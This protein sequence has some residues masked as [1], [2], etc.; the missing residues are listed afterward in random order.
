MK[1]I[2]HCM[3]IVVILSLLFTACYKDII[4]PES[5]PDG[6]PQSVSYKEDLAPLFQAKCT[7]VG[8]HV[9][10][11][12]KPYMD[13]TEESFRNIVNGGFVNTFLPKESILYK[14]VNG[15]MTEFIPSKKDKQLVYDWIRNG[16]PNN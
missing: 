5:D 10:G 14:Q 2:N 7:N 11:G 4:S 8:C 6:P 3:V 12:H 15:G 1:K 13:K 16:A 9:A